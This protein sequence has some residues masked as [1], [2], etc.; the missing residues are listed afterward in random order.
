MP[1]RAISCHV[2]PCRASARTASGFGSVCSDESMSRWAKIARIECTDQKF[3]PTQPLRNI[4]WDSLGQ[5]KAWHLRDSSTVQTAGQLRPPS[6][7]AGSRPGTL[8][9]LDEPETVRGFDKSDILWYSSIFAALTTKHS[10]RQHHPWIHLAHPFCCHVGSFMI[11]PLLPRPGSG[12]TTDLHSLKRRDRVVKDEDAGFLHLQRSRKWTTCLTKRYKKLKLRKRCWKLS[13][14][15]FHLDL[16][17]S[18]PGSS[19]PGCTSFTPQH[20][21]IHWANGN[22]S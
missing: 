14:R 13:Y 4:S 21:E 12:E 6:L 11:F 22:L 20:I 7:L 1:C 5:A 9:F 8:I 18:W 15:W 10:Q 17:V 19:V 2:V 3:F 16:D